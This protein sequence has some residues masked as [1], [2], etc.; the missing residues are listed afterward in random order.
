MVSS[1]D[2]VRSTTLS[3]ENLS[4]SF[5]G[6]PLFDGVSF[7][8]GTGLLAVAGPNGSGKTTLLK[9]LAGLLAPTA[10]STAS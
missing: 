6:T 5:S 3:A 9:I 8:A 10:G 2:T 4:K 7:E 1:M